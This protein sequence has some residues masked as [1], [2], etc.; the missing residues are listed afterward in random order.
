VY[1]EKEIEVPSDIRYLNIRL[2][3][4]SAGTVWFDD[5]RLHPSD[6]QMITYTYD[7]LKGMTSSTD[8]RGITTYYEYDSFGRL[9]AVKDQERNII[10]SYKYNYAQ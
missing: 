1:I 8:E 4:K 3:N 7:P 9:E 5:I 10:K 2:D 6:A